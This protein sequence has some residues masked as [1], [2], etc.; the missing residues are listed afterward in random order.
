MGTK[1]IPAV[2][3]KFCDRCGVE[4]PRHLDLVVDAHYTGRDFSGAAV[5][6]NTVK[7]ELC[8]PCESDFNKFIKDGK[9]N[10]D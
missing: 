5:G 9:V 6:G 1:I 4:N 10:N 7:Y 3:T 8:P 2:E